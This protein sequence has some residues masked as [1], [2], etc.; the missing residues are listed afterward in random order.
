MAQHLGKEQQEQSEQN[1]QTAGKPSV[2]LQSKLALPVPL[3]VGVLAY[4]LCLLLTITP[5]QRIAGSV[6]FAQVHITR[7]L[8]IWSAWLPANLHLAKDPATA[9]QSTGTLELGVLLALA[10]VCY[11]YCAW[12]VQRQPGASPTRTMLRLIVLGTVLAGLIF[13]LAPALL[14]QRI[15]AF[16]DYGHSILTY[17]I[18]PY[19]SPPT[20]HPENPLIAYDIWRDTTAASGP[21]W[22]TICSFIA[23]VGG[24]HPLRYIVAFRLLGLIMH[25]LNI[26]LVIAILRKWGRSSRLVALGALLY[27]WNPLIIV[28]TC[29][30]GYND[31][32][33]LTFILLGIFLSVQGE[34]REQEERGSFLSPVYYLPP[35]IAFT[36]AALCQL[37]VWP[38]IVFFLLLLACKAFHAAAAGSTPSEKAVHL[39]ESLAI[40]LSGILVSVVVI[41]ALYGPFW[42][43]HSLADIVNS[44]R[45]SP[46]AQ[47][48]SGS[49]LAAIQQSLTANGTSTASNVL[50]QRG[51]WDALGTGVSVIGLLLGGFFLWRRPTTRRLAL[52]ALGTFAALLLVTPWFQPSYLIWL[53][54]IAMICLPTTYKRLGWGL[55]AFALIASVSAYLVFLVNGYQP[56]GIW[57]VLTPLLIFAPPVLAFLVGFF[58]KDTFFL[59]EFWKGPA[60]E[61]PAL[62]IKDAKA[63]EGQEEA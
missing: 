43:S 32:F 29:L 52:A 18:N 62:P 8:T 7:L 58:L 51:T 36:L 24:E 16:A 25:L 60:N 44:L 6:H 39:R 4:L 47:L 37:I 38:L 5:L 11:G 9:R 41:L 42:R 28:E 40:L 1:K 35:L 21:L 59:A 56:A 50:S 3:L 20:T 19:F 48:A 31:T 23:Q 15:F 57:I 63:D 22:L 27:G 54:G 30:N 17:H 12:Q 45:A 49:I 33:V 46:T 55:I 26:F 10:F 34:Q 13:I 53:V 2:S 14:S 61:Q